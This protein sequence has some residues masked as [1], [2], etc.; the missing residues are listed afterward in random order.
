MIYFSSSHT[1][2][3]NDCDLGNKK[4]KIE[5]GICDLSKSLYKD[6]NYLEDLV[7]FC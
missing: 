3:W 5:N 6:S 4:Y 1:I 7:Y 2:L